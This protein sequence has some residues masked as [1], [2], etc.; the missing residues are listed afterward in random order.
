MNQLEWYSGV[1]D[2]NADY[3]PFEL[4]QDAYLTDAIIIDVTFDNRLYCC[5]SEVT[6][7]SMPHP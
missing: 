5:F 2:W 3:L 1:L 7:T 6:E 4:W